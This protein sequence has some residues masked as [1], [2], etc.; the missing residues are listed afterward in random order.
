MSQASEQTERDEETGAVSGVQRV[1]PS[2]GDP[3]ARK[4]AAERR[5]LVETIFART[6]DS[7]W[8]LRAARDLRESDPLVDNLAAFFSGEP[9]TKHVRVKRERKIALTRE[10]ILTA[11]AET[12]G[13][14]TAVAK[15]LGVSR[16]TLLDRLVLYGILDQFNASR[17][18][19]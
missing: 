5:K 3:G 8:A 2:A 11:K 6:R 10:T 4:R 7:S 18:A 9:R 17:K 14:H 19:Q 13:T 16:R 1:A 12:A 15:K